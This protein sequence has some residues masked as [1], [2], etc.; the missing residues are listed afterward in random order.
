MVVN[1]FL[2]APIKLKAAVKN[3]LVW[4]RST[5]VFDFRFRHLIVAYLRLR[6]RQP[7]TSALQDK[8]PLHVQSCR[9]ATRTVKVFRISSCER[10]I[11]LPRVREAVLYAKSAAVAFTIQSTVSI[12]CFGSRNLSK[13]RYLHFIPRSEGTSLDLPHCRAAHADY[14][15][16]VSSTKKPRYDS[17]SHRQSPRWSCPPL[18]RATYATMRSFTLVSAIAA[19]ISTVSTSYYGCY[20]A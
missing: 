9:M 11:L 6:L 17:Y 10:M 15:L 4:M 2:P 7:L 13:L 16:W 1:E 3:R 18:P 8:I 19:F 5:F 20:P 12:K 14:Q